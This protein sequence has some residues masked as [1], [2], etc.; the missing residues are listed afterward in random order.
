MPG[1]S[2]GELDRWLR[3]FREHCVERH[4]LDPND[5][6]RVAWFNLEVLIL[7]MLDR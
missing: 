3:E 5:T 4:G 7:T 6:E 1:F 2:E